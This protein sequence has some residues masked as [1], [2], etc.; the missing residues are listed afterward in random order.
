MK[1]ID[2][3]AELVKSINTK[4]IGKIAADIAF[5]KG[6]IFTAGNGGSASTASHLVNDLL[7]SKNFPYQHRIRAT[8]LCDNVAAITAISNDVNFKWVFAQILENLGRSGDIL[9]VISTSGNSMNLVRAAKWAKSIG[10]TVIGLLGIG[11]FLKNMVDDAILVDSDDCGVV[12][13]VHLLIS[14]MISDEVREKLL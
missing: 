9:I 6:S 13:S 10:M 5:C 3:V 8:S 11:G 4:Q 2:K 1:N 12:E 14:H 7:G